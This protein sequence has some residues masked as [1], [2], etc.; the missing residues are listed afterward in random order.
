MDRMLWVA[1]TGAA[2]L[3]E[4]QA[5]VAHNLAN[6]ST[7]GYRADLH[8]FS[9]Y[10]VQG[11]GFPTRVNAVNQPLG[12]DPRIGTLQPTGRDL[13]IA[14]RGDGWIAVQA[15]DGTEAYTRAGSLRRTATGLLETAQG[16][17]VLGDG[18]PLTLPALQQL[19][20]GGDGTLSIVPEGLGPETVAAVARLKLVNPPADQL[21]KGPDGLMRMKDGTTAPAD[22]SVRVVSGVVESSNVNVAETLVE[23]IEIA[24]QYE[25]QVRMM[26]TAKQTDQAAQQLLRAA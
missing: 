19:E 1:T 13:D 7:D 26:D 17:P 25:L 9:S 20:I 4:A 8:A 21:A 23:M 2:E 22:A 12:F 15:P 5:T 14:I 3:L 6:A 24:R 10:L 18:G 11:P 16:H